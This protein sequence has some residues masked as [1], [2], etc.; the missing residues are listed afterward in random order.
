M[1]RLA[2]LGIAAVIFGLGGAAGCAKSGLSAQATESATRDFRQRYERREFGQL[3]ANS[4][5]ELRAGAS[6][7]LFVEAMRNISQKL[8]PWQSAT[9]LGAARVAGEDN[10]FVVEYKSQF[11][12]GEATEHFVWRSDDG[13][14]VLVGYHINSRTLGL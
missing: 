14:P 6:E 7:A 12:N 1:K 4:A 13:R 9:P 8:G 10:K 11:S 2:P 3:Y 5:P